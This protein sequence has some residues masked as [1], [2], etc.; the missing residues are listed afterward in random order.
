MVP[1]L[2]RYHD[3]FKVNDKENYPW[4][5]KTKLDINMMP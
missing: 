3:I 2:E 5:T 4:D 1:C